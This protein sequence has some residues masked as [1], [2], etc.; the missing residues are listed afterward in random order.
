VDP[1]LSVIALKSTYKGTK[2]YA[3][4]VVMVRSGYMTIIQLNDDA[5]H[6]TA[7]RLLMDQIVQTFAFK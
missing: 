2:V 7:D 6:E 4:R 1:G 3:I 5:G